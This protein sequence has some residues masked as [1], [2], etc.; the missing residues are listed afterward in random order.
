MFQCLHFFKIIKRLSVNTQW[1]I[2]DILYLKV[3]WDPNNDSLLLFA[4]NEFLQTYY[5]GD[6]HQIMIS[7]TKQYR[8]LQYT[9]MNDKSYIL[10]NRSLWVAAIHIPNDSS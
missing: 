1:R 4:S 10:T 6:V 3:L 9:W 2:S 5:I 7:I 8:V